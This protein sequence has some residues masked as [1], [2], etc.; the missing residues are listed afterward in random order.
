[1]IKQALCGM[2]MWLIA[3]IA[4]ADDF[5]RQKLTNWHQFRGPLSTG[6]APHGDPPLE[7]SESK[8]IKWKVAIPGQGSASP[9]V[10]GDR[11][12]LLTA[13]KTD[14]TA[15][16]SETAAAP[17]ATSA[18]FAA[19]AT[20]P[21][22]RQPSADRLA[23]R[24]DRPRG[25][26]GGFGIVPPQNVYQFV[27]LC[28]DRKTG[29]TIWQRTAVET[30]PHEGHHQTASFASA[31]AITN[32]KQLYASFGSRGIFCYD[33]DGNL[34]WE[35][36]LGDMQTRHS[37]GEGSSPAL[38]GDT[39]VA[40]WDH[41][42]DSFIAAL[43]ANTGDEK[44]RQPRDEPSTWAT[45]LIVEAAGRTQVVTSGTNRVRSYDFKSGELIWE[46]GGLGSNP[47]ATP[48]E[49]EGLAIAMSGHNDPAGVAVPLS[50]KGDVT[51][52]QRIAW[53]VD[54]ITPYVSTP[55]LYE[56]TLYFPKS[57]NAILSAID[58]K[59]GETIIDQERLPEMSSM[60]SSPVAANGR[61][62][63]PSREGTTVVIEHAPTLQILATNEIDETI[64]ATPAI[65][66]N[67]MYIRG[68]NHLYCIA[69]PQ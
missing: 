19:H 14:R 16:S 25:A 58:A 53:Q 66:G 38:H 10:W 4:S 5:E 28:L 34:R 50:A 69:E 32:G 63:L 13:I 22:V 23:Q 1:M 29:D 64:D 27:V 56:G 6:V 47:I 48:I 24:G 51:G 43:D 17:L 15:E 9:I 44:W 12:Y 33:L 39:L 60:Y 54:S 65:V 59:S 3:C 8:N 57:R 35:K 36:D 18:R 45:P 30:V 11:I 26:R 62:Y 21:K 31:S 67:E 61:I 46:C 49:Y 55:V 20:P 41:E 2:A 40:V 37:F 52:S 68:E 42:G 7:W